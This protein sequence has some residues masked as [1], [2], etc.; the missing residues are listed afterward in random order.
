MASIEVEAIKTVLNLGENIHDGVMK[1]VRAK[2]ASVVVFGVFALIGTGLNSGAT[3]NVPSISS[4]TFVP[5]VDN[6]FCYPA[7][8]LVGFYSVNVEWTLGLN[9]NRALGSH[10]SP[11]ISAAV[12]ALAESSLTLS[13]KAPTARLASELHL[14]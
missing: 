8:K 10:M 4:T 14:L 2:I 12:R 13:G 1:S 5:S 7:I 11:G 3:A 6:A 9:D